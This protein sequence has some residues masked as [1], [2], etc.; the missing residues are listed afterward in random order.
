MVGLALDNRQC[1]IE[2]YWA[3]RAYQPMQGSSMAER[4]V[5]DQDVVGSIPTL[6]ALGVDP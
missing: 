1:P 4:L 2:C 6:A 5:L 3:W